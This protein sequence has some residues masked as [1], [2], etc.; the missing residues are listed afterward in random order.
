MKRGQFVK[1][2]YVEV[3]FKNVF[4]YGIRY[5]CPLPHFKRDSL[6]GL[7]ILVVRHTSIYGVAR[8]AR[9]VSFVPLSKAAEIV[10]LLPC[11][12]ASLV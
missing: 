4:W 1:W 2:S 8:L 10:S 11:P 12:L 5:P 9:F 6:R 7:C 3:R